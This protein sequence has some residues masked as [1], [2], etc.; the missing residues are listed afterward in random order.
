[1]PGAHARQPLS[2][3]CPGDPASPRAAGPPAAVNARPRAQAVEL[4]RRAIYHATH[5]DA[6]S[7]GTVRVYHIDGKGWRRI[8]EDDSTKLH[9]QYNNLA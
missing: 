7:G 4:G 8:S 3:R 2:P 6:Y 1:M 9:Y 5:N